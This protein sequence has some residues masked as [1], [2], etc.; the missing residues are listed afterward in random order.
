MQLTNSAF[1]KIRNDLNGAWR[2]AAMQSPNFPPEM[3]A[4]ARLAGSAQQGTPTFGQSRTSSLG[5]STTPAFGRP[6]F[7]QPAF[8]TSAFGSSSAPAFSQ[9]SGFGAASHPSAFGAFSAFSSPKPGPFATDQPAASVFGQ[10]AP[11]DPSFAQ[12]STPTPAFGQA[13]FGGASQGSTAPFGSSAFSGE[14]A[15][16]A[17]GSPATRGGFSAFASPDGT[18]A[19]FGNPSSNSVASAFASSQPSQTSTFARPSAFGQSPTFG[20]TNVTSAIAK[21]Q[22]YSISTF[23]SLSTSQQSQSAFRTIPEPAPTSLVMNPFDQLLPPNYMEMMPNTVREK[24]EAEEFSLGEIPEWI[25]P[26]QLRM[27]QNPTLFS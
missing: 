27:S 6:A 23:P 2:Q 5:Q 25:P 21:P 19:P 22:D 16:S 11:P 14:G 10:P 18:S 26:P 24:F 20:Q 17:F 8:G 1:D 7:G 9:T 4:Q 12:P 13:S 15:Q 3:L